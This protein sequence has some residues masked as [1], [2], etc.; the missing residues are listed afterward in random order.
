MRYRDEFATSS[1]SYSVAH[2]MRFLSDYRTYHIGH[3]RTNERTKTFRRHFI[4]EHAAADDD[5]SY[6]SHLSRRRFSV[7]VI[8]VQKVLSITIMSRLTHD[9]PI[10]LP[11]YR[12]FSRIIRSF[13]IC[14][15]TFS[16]IPVTALNYNTLLDSRSGEFSKTGEDFHIK[17]IIT[18]L[19]VL[20]FAARRSGNF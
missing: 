16:P 18:K 5:A 7:Y 17:K 15:Y 9:P 13:P 4:A 20:I 2:G 1:T 10:P 14:F 12:S 3:E 8:E 19:I 6:R 11:H